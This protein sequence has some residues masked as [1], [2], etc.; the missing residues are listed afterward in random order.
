MLQNL[1]QPDEHSKKMV[2]VYVYYHMLEVF[3]ALNKALNKLN[4]CIS[5]SS[6][7]NKS[8]QADEWLCPLDHEELIQTGVD[9]CPECSEPTATRR[10]R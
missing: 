6:L 1:E 7:P 9:I 5:I 4:L 2:A 8:V 3:Q 10:S